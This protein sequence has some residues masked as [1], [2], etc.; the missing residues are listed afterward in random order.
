M[1]WDILA[2]QFLSTTTIIRVYKL[3]FPEQYD[4]EKEI[5]KSICVGHLNSWLHSSKIIIIIIVINAG[6][7][8][9]NKD[10]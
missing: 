7:I 6:H 1:Q 4:R 3:Y 5:D 8:A 10:R 9:W 2:T